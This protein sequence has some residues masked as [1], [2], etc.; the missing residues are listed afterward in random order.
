MPL[1]GNIK[2]LAKSVLEAIGLIASTFARDV[3]IQKKIFGLDMETLILSNEE[4]DDIMEIVKSLE[5]S[6]LLIKG[7]IE[8]IENEAKE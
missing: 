1:A 8:T 7:V 3:A 6:D 4:M 5:V 2:S